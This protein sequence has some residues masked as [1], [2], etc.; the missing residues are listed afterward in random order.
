[1]MHEP[2]PNSLR[3]EMNAVLIFKSKWSFPALQPG[4]VSGVISSRESQLHVSIWP[5]AGRR[6]QREPGFRVFCLRNGLEVPVPL[7]LRDLSRLALL[8]D[9]DGTLL[10]IAPT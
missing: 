4:L 10:D 8:L 6:L 1:M 9:V 3:V 5:G 2:Q 7:D